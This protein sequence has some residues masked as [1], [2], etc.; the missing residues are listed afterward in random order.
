MGLIAWLL[1]L[2]GLGLGFCIIPQCGIVSIYVCIAVRAGR[3]G[4][5]KGQK[6]RAHAQQ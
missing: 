6:R 2:A 1:G 4:D 3:V 5:V